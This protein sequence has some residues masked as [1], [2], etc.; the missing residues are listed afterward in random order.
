VRGPF[1]PFVP[2]AGQLL[3]RIL[4]RITVRLPLLVSH[5]G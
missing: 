4:L 2:F 1:V 3:V 5:A